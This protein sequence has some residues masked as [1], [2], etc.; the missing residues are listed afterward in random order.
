MLPH[1]QHFL[2]AVYLLE[3]DFA[4][5]KELFDVIWQEIQNEKQNKI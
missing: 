1:G 3:G 2:G 4:K 5:A